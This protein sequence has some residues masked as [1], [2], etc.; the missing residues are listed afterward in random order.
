MFLLFHYQLYHKYDL[1][2]EFLFNLLYFNIS[3][4][5]LQPAMS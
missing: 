5:M 1:I 2:V 4:K 3:C